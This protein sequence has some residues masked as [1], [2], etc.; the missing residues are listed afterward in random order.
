MQA[1]GFQI[2]QT[3][4]EMNLVDRLGYLQFDEDDVFDELVNSIFPDHDPIVSNDHGML[5]RDGE[6]RLAELVH[7]CVFIDFL[8]KSGSQRVE[9]RQ[10]ATNDSFGQEVNGSAL[11]G[12]GRNVLITRAIACRACPPAGK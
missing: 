2:I 7:Q 10:G 4:R 5:L 8:K 11:F 3:L 1:C 9:H 6:S 12:M